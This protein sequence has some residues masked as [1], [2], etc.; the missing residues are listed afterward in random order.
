VS[1]SAARLAMAAGQFEDGNALYG[2]CFDQTSTKR[3]LCLG[4]IRGI[5]DA[6]SSN[7]INGY[8]ACLPNNVKVGQGDGCCN[9]IS[10]LTPGK[11]TSGGRRPGRFG[12]LRSFPVPMMPTLRN[13]SPSIP[14]LEDD[15][16]K[17]AQGELKIRAAGGAP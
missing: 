7:A 2:A 9:A 15:H 10:R 13:L 5:A 17:F 14:S 16:A 3:G 12:P 6:L 4:Y 8:T 1:V 11:A